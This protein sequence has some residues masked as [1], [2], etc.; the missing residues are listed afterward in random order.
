MVAKKEKLM[1][2]AIVNV[3]FSL[4]GMR[5]DGGRQRAMGVRDEG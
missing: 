5:K 1:P 4:V 3:F 2:V